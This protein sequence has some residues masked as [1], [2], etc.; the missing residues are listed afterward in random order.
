MASGGR[1]RKPDYSLAV[2]TDMKR[3]CASSA[4]SRGCRGGSRFNR[5]SIILH[6]ELLEFLWVFLELLVHWCK[7]DPTH[8][9]RKEIGRLAVEIEYDKVRLYVR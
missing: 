5:A 1:T 2:M 9:N 4:F 8:P 3:R 6:S 7:E